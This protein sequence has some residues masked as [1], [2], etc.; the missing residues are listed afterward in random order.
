MTAVLS[1]TLVREAS[2]QQC[3][4]RSLPR[5]GIRIRPIDTSARDHMAVKAR[6]LLERLGKTGK[7]WERLGKTGKAAS[8]ARN[9]V[10][11]HRDAPKNPAEGQ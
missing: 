4:A 7:D 3:P 10:A 1:V 11:V 2:L 6:R 9:T 5:C 8:M